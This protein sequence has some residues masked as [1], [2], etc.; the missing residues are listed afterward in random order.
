MK[1]LEQNRTG[2]IEVLQRAVAMDPQSA[3]ALLFYSAIKMNLMTHSIL[4]QFLGYYK[5][6]VGFGSL[7]GGFQ[8]QA[9]Q[10]LSLHLTLQVPGKLVEPLVMCHGNL[11]NSLIMAHF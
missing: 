4:S 3:A 11:A 10:F 2:A 5:T 1:R 9:G 7:H 6:A 8:N